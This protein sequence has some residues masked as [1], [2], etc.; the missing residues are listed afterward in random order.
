MADVSELG[1]IAADLMDELE[2]DFYDREDVKLGALAVIA[3][4]NF[5]EG[6]DDVCVIVYRCSD[7]RRWIQRALF[8]EAEDA[9]S[10]ST[11]TLDDE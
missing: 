3:E 6:D 1:V 10:H 11:E 8:R 2:A 4:V 5:V 9:V 7:G